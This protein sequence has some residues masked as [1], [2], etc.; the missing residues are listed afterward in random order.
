MCSRLRGP[1]SS[2]SIIPPWLPVATSL[3]TRQ[4]ITVC[5]VEYRPSLWKIANVELCRTCGHQTIYSVPLRRETYDRLRSL[6]FHQVALFYFFYIKINISHERGLGLALTWNVS[7][8]QSASVCHCMSSTGPKAPQN[9]CLCVTAMA[10][11]P[12]ATVLVRRCLFFHIRRKLFTAIGPR[13]QGP[14]CGI[15]PGLNWGSYTC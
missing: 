3:H 14:L 15:I 5:Q 1:S 11:A 9:S 4:T 13:L 6:A 10:S 7:W 8:Q 12:L 2:K